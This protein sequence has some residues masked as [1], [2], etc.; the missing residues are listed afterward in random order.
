LSELRLSEV[1]GGPPDEAIKRPG[2]PAVF[3]PVVAGDEEARVEEMAA[4]WDE[5]R[6]FRFSREWEI[7]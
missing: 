5:L 3:P 6:L 7:L 2:V 4:D 1:L